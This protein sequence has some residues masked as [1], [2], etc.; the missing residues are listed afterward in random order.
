MG[1][2][3]GLDPAT[4]LLVGVGQFVERPGEPG[5]AARSAVGLAAEAAHRA[6]ADAGIAAAE[7]DT[8]AGVR[9]FEISIRAPRR[10]SAA[11]TTSP[12]PSPGVSGPTRAA[13]SWRSPVA[14]RRSTW[15]PSSPA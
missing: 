8:I 11:R 9:Q 5:Y 10:R 13:P 3:H 14:R 15:P 6:L 2:V 12:A 4:P 7:V 1:N